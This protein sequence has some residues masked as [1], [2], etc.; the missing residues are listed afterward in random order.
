MSKGLEALERVRKS[1]CVAS[2]VMQLQHED[3]E[4][5][6][7]LDIIEKEL[8]DYENLKL[9]HRS[10]QDEVLNDFKK[11]KALEI[12][13]EKGVNLYKLKM[14]DSVEE[15]NKLRNSDL[16]LSQKEYDILKEVLL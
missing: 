16:P 7:A 1:H 4:T 11:L 6:K 12:I 5:I 9:K 13:K 14:C 8:K 15:Y 2:M 10:M 3:T